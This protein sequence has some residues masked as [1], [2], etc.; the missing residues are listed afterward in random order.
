MPNEDYVSCVHCIYAEDCF[1]KD[2]KDWPCN[3]VED[4]PAATVK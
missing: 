1:N 2:P 3:S 4:S